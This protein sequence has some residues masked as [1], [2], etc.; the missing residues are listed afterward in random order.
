MDTADVVALHDSLSN[1]G[2]WGADD[3]LGALNLITPQVPAAGAAT[4]RSGRTV[5]CAR[6]LNTDPAPDN[7]VPVAHH[8]IGT[9][10]EGWGTDYV[11]LAPHGFATSHIDALSHV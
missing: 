11:A 9:A 5:S 10:T 8:M 2:R 7:P 1:W 3:Q 4:V 6:P